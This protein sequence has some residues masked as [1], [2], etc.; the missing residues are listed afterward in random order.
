MA[1]SKSAALSPA[2]PIA[3][4]NLGPAVAPTAVIASLNA[5]C[6]ILPSLSA[7]CSAI[8]ASCGCSNAPVASVSTGR[9]S[10]KLF[11]SAPVPSVA[12]LVICA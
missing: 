1:F 9:S 10:S 7:A 4:A 8:T 11:L 6:D 2:T 5:S 3:A 12:A